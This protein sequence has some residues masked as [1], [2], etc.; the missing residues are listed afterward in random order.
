MCIIRTL[1]REDLYF[2][3]IIRTKQY[4]VGYT[5]S[6]VQTEGEITDA[7]GRLEGEKCDFAW[8]KILCYTLHK[9]VQSPLGMWHHGFL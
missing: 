6:T 5:T 7:L 4:E 9:R 2:V 1:H 3:A 8:L